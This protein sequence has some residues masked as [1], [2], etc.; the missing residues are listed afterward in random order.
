M[1]KRKRDEVDDDD[2]END[3]QAEEALRLE[4]W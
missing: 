1:K 4:Q 3:A 2:F